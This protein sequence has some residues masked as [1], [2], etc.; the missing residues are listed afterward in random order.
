MNIAKIKQNKIFD[1]ILRNL[2]IILFGTIIF[3]KLMVYAKQISPEYLYM[4]VAYPIFASVLIVASF[5][6]LFENRKRI[7]FLYTVNLIVSLVLISDIVYYE[8]FKDVTTVASLRNIKL[9]GGV[10]SSVGDLFNIK[11]LLYLVDCIVLIPFLDIYK[12]FKKDHKS[13]ILKKLSIFFM[14][15]VIGISIDAKSVVAV[16]KE[17]PTLLSSMSNRIYLT[18]MIGNL[19]FHAVDAY[20][21]I[22]TKVKNSKK[23]SAANEQEIKG[24]LNNNKSTGTNLQGAAQGKKFNSYPG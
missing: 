21:Y 23:L 10:S 20:N 16:S 9:L 12:K 19:N 17:Q 24:F 11:D 22:S 6:I 4:K 14:I 8:Y 2:D 1:F 7:N 3:I 5:S 13:S 18:K 15:F